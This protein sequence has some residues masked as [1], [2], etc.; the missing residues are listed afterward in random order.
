MPRD[1]LKP[2]IGAAKKH[3]AYEILIVSVLFLLAI[4]GGLVI[5]TGILA[6]Q[7]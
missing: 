1:P 7:V 2:E 5:N 4:V 3:N 6:R